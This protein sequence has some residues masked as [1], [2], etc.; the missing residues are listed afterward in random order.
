MRSATEIS[1]KRCG[2]WDSEAGFLEKQQEEIR[3]K[4]FRKEND[5]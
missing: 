2:G 4:P 3:E 1:R 5:V